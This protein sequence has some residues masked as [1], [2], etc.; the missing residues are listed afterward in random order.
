MDLH[1]QADEFKYISYD[2]KL[3]SKVLK[4]INDQNTRHRAGGS[5]FEELFEPQQNVPL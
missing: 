5:V 2:R 3:A 4:S 1:T